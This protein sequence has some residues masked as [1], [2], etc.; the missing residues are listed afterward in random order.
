MWCIPTRQGLISAMSPLRTDHL[1][2]YQFH[3]LSKMTDLEQIFAP[4]GAMETFE[5]AKKAGKVRFIGFSAHSVEVALDAMDRYPFDTI[6]FPVN[7]VLYSQAKF[8]PQV[9]DKARQKKMGIMALKGWLR[10]RGRLRQRTIILIPNAGTNLRHFRMKPLW[11]CAGHYR[12]RLPPQLLRVMSGISGWEWILVRISTRLPTPSNNS[13]LPESP[14]SIPSST[15]V[16]SRF[17][18]NSTDELLKR[19]ATRAASPVAVLLACAKFAAFR[20]P[21]LKARS[22]SWHRWPESNCC[23]AYC[24]VSPRDPFALTSAGG[25]LLVT[26]LLAAWWRAH[27]ASTQPMEASRT[28]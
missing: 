13:L 20:I 21:V 14:V 5:A 4:K 18:R 26:G 10:Q 27:R 25:V 8:G 1:D 28:E 23:V 6:L 12:S 2:L 9:L 3:A 11:V 15:S 16:Q 17:L 7:F 24:S 22:V 19:R